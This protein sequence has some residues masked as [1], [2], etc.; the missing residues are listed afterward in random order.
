[1]RRLS[2]PEGA[3]R[4]LMLRRN[5]MPFWETHWPVIQC[6]VARNRGIVLE[7]YR[8][9]SALIIVSHFRGSLHNR[10]PVLPQVS[11]LPA[12]PEVSSSIASLKAY[13]A[14]DSG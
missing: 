11:E 8:P 2:R 3:G 14:A 13:E 1:M 7:G 6:A 10:V 5:C 4:G 9:W 12:C